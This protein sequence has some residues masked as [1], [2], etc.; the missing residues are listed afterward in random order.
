MEKVFVEHRQ[1]FLDALALDQDRDR[2]RIATDW[3][4]A[5]AQRYADLEPRMDALEEIV[6]REGAALRHDDLAVEHE[7]PGLEGGRGRDQFGKIA[8][9]RLAGFRL[10]FDTV[11][12][13][14]EKTAEAVPFRLVL[15]VLALRDRVHGQGFHRREGSFERQRHAR[16]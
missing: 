7:A 4:E 11:T 8:R 6:E 10:Q 15:P 3:L 9:Q 14:E 16:V 2:L 13:A 12:V 1:A 5:H